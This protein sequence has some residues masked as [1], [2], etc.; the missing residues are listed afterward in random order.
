MHIP[1][2]NE[3]ER[4]SEKSKSRKFSSFDSLILSNKLAKSAILMEKKVYNRIKAVLAEKG[5]SNIWL[6]EQLKVH[7]TTVSKWCQNEMQYQ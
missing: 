4:D 6:S 3:L 5:K 7:Q 2:L 1:N